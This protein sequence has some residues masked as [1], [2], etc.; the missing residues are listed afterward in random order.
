[1]ED[2]LFAILSNRLVVSS[3]YFIQVTS[4]IAQFLEFPVKKVCKVGYGQP[5]LFPSCQTNHPLVKQI[6]DLFPNKW[7]DHGADRL[8]DGDIYAIE[9]LFEGGVK[10]RREYFG[11]NSPFTK[12]YA[13][14]IEYYF[15]SIRDMRNEAEVMLKHVY[16]ILQNESVQKCILEKAKDH[17]KREAELAQQ[18][19]EREA[20]VKRKYDEEHLP[21]YRAILQKAESIKIPKKKKDALQV[22]PD[23]FEALIYAMKTYSYDNYPSKEARVLSIRFAPDHPILV[24]MPNDILHCL[25]EKDN[26]EYIL[27]YTWDVT[28]QRVH[29]KQ[30]ELLS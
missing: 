13:F 14:R 3:G 8:S 2:K 20:E 9:Q 21:K 6:H 27:K 1:M 18:E 19:K 15:E 26:K 10:M 12:G 29:K 28:L 30:K 25:D 22:Q 24:W 16:K 4:C 17:A 11:D 23:D 7:F 5:S